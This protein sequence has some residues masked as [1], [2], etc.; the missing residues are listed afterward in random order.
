MKSNALIIFN[1]HE[2]IK[3]CVIGVIAF[4]ALDAA[5]YLFGE[6]LD[7]YSNHVD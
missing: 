6:A 1:V 5:A 7:K 4:K 3:N 2:V